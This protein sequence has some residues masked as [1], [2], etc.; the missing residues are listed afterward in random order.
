MPSIC[1]I[2]IASSPFKIKFKLQFDKSIPSVCGPHVD[3]RAL[4]Y[5]L[6]LG[7]NVS[8]LLY[9][10]VG[11]A[12]NKQSALGELRSI[13]SSPQSD[14]MFKVDTFE[15]LDRIRNQLKKRITNTEG[16]KI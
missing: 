2:K 1:D 9:V 8:S 4:D 7:C 6:N 3:V 15:S 13:A 5:Y 12:F 16:M 14:H 11:D 10:K